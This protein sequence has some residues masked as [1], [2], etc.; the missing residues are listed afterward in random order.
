MFIG[1][2]A[3]ALA[4]KR[5]APD[6]SLGTLFLSAQFVDLLWPLFLLIGVEHVRIEPGNTAVMPLDFYDYP[7][8]HSF[9]VSIV[10]SVALGL[11]YFAFR[12]YP[13]GAW[14]VGL[15][16]FSHWILDAIVH[17]PDLPL[18]PGSNIRIGFGLW[19]SM[20]GSIVVE[21]GI[22]LIGL[23]L[24][25]R[26]TVARDRVGKFGVWSLGFVLSI[27]W[28]VNI[29]G[30]QPPSETAIAVVGNASWLFDFWAYWGDRHRKIRPSVA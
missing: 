15:C 5:A 22:F 12:R 30:P 21:F 24:Y 2:Y 14:I 7:F 25:L 29:F 18:M 3:V 19:N 26:A 10:W 11:L 8:S 16:V 9:V 27:I 23:V 17:R 28:I 4:S 20:A 1:H 13:R 6:T